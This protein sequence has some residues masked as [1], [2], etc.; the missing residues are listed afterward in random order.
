MKKT[1]IIIAACVFGIFSIQAFTT[2][3]DQRWKN[4]QILPQSISED[5]LDSIMDHFA[6]SLGVKCN[7]CHER[8]T[9]TNKLDFAGDAKPEKQFARKMMLM[10]IDINKNYF[11]EMEEGEVRQDTTAASY[12]LQQVTCYTCHK[13]G[14]HPKNQPPKKED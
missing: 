14:T 3:P 9:T 4:L 6:L 5:A 8:N 7:Y 11:N 1:F 13:G 10:A 12:M 2:K